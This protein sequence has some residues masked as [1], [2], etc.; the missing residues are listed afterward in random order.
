MLRTGRG[1]G[2][3]SRGQVEER[4]QRGKPAVRGNYTR[5]SKRSL[6]MSFHVSYQQLVAAERAYFTTHGEE[7]TAAGANSNNVWERRLERMRWA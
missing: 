7:A 1:G 5:V 4:V 3:L 6:H 2:G